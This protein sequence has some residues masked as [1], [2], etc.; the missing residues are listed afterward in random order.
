MQYNLHLVTQEG[1]ICHADLR[2]IGNAIGL[3]SPWRVSPARNQDD[4]PPD[5]CV[6]RTY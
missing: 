5:R 4:C 2:A 1:D 3:K 6:K